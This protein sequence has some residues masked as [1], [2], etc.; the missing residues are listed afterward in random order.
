[1]EQTSRQFSSERSQQKPAISIG[2][3]VRAAAGRDAER[4]FIVVGEE[5]TDYVFSADG[6]TRPIEKPKRKKWK[7]LREV[8]FSGTE[9]IGLVSSGELTNKE[10]RRLLMPFNRQQDASGFDETVS[11]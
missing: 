11:E 2:H 9:T 5:N 7:H 6:K 4:Y 3:I 1:M 8:G 10:L